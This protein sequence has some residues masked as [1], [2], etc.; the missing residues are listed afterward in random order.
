MGKDK[1]KHR[2]KEKI[3]NNKYYQRFFVFDSGIDLTDDKKV[4]HR[5]NVVIKNIIF[6]SNLI[7]TLIFTFI[8]FGD[9]SNWVLTIILFPVTFFVNYALTKL[10]K[11]GPEDDLSQKIAMYFACFYMFLSSIIIYIKLKNGTQ[12]YL[13][14]A[15]YIL[16]Y[17]SILISA[18]Y[19]DRVL[20]KNV[21]AVAFIVVTILHFTVTYNI[22]AMG[23][24]KSF[25]ELVGEFFASYEFRDILLRTLLLGLFSLVAYIFVSM[26][27]NMQDERKQELIKRKAV[28]EDFIDIISDVFAVSIKDEVKSQMD[29]DYIKIEALMSKKLASLYNLTEEEQQKIYDFCLVVINNEFKND[30]DDTLDEDMKYQDVKTKTSLWIE[31]IKR[32]NLE[33]ECEAI[34]R[35]TFEKS[36]DDGFKLSHSMVNE[37]IILQIVL[38]CEI[39]VT[40]RRPDKRYKNAFSDEGSIEFMQEKIKYYFNPNLFD[41]FITYQEEFNEIYV[42]NN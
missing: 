4:L 16:L 11:K 30:F 8:S 41:R 7:Y 34:L 37:D 38:L 26:T 5:K 24:D 18:Y 25:F 17:Y 3:V 14:E 15:G 1:L 28:Q 19:Q 42:N 10:I 31:L 33:K 6:L 36:N 21:I 32:N 29:I 12:D 35:A 20:L 9:K 40:L 22:V 27:N 2:L 23:N 39:Y 13:K